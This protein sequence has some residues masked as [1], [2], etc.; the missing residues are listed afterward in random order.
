MFDAGALI[1]TIK[2]AGAQVFQ[3]DLRQ[4]DQAIEKTGRTAAAAKAPVEQLGTATDTTGKKSRAAKKPLDDQARSTERVGEEAA[5]AKPKQES[6]AAASERQAQSARQLSVALLAAGVAVT[7][8]VG[9]TV[10]KFASFDQA[11][12]NTAAATM[13]T[14][15]QQ[16][17]LGAAALEAGADSA[18]SA[19]EAAAAEEELAKAGLSV[20]EIIGGGLNASLGLAAAGQLEVAR[21][22]E[23]MATTLKQFK[24]PAEDAA[25]VSD[26]LAAGAGKAQGS[27]ED[28]ANAL[29]YVGPV[30]NG[31]G[32][33]VEETTGILALFAEQGILGEQA[34]TSLRGVLSSL[35]SPS[36]IAAATMKDYNVQ[37]FDGTGKM[38]SGAAVAQELHKAFDGLS[39]AERSAAMGRIFGNEQIT[40]A[41]ILMRG[42]ADAVNEWTEAVDDSGFAAE[43]AAKR[44]DN[45]AGDV[46]KLGGAFD[47]ALI[48]TGSG[49]NDV[50][51][52]MVQAVTGLVDGY[53]ELPDPVQQTTLVLGAAL[54]AMLLF[55]GGAL[56]AIS[57][58]ADLKKTLDG[59]NLTM[60]K[61]TLIAGGVGLALTAVVAVIGL[62]AT[63][64]AEAEQKA[65]SYSQALSQTGD[66][67]RK[68]VRETVSA[69]LAMKESFLWLESDSAY[70]AATKL[71]LSLDV[72]TDA[73]EGSAPALRKLN[74]Q[75]A[76]G[77]NGSARQKKRLEETGLSL[78]DY[79]LA[80]TTV[81]QAIDR[82]N[83][84]QERGAE[85]LGQKNEVTDDA[86]D[87][88]RNAAG[89][90][91]ASADEVSNYKDE[92]DGLIDQIM[93]L[94]GLNQDAASAQIDYGNT[95]AEVDEVIRKATEGLDENGDGVADYALTLD[96]ATQAGRDNKEMLIGL[97]QEAE[98]AARK[99]YEL[100]GNTEN[101]KATLEDSRQAL[102][103]RILAFTGNADAAGALADEIFRIP[104]K[105]EWDMIADTSVA[106][107]QA[108]AMA[109]Q[110]RD[111]PHSK[112]VYLYI[113]EQRIASGAPR[114]EVGAA[115]GANGFVLESYANGGT[116]EHHVA[117]IA[118]AGTWRVW[119]EDETGGEA[120]IPLAES[121]RPR[122]TAIL[123]DVAQRF[124]Y[125]LT[126]ADAQRY[127]DGAVSTSTDAS[128]GQPSGR[129]D[130]NLHVYYP[131]GIDPVRAIQEAAEARRAEGD[132]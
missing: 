55:S 102:Y 130:L 23:I 114:G 76:L 44:Q 63:A 105:T 77:E 106:M 46:E 65:E 131:S 31:L 73:A 84:A 47:T 56:G 119:A 101:Y 6:Q 33:S 43:Q 54:G 91:Q 112:T 9:L 94:N 60:G 40:A 3:Q 104:S 36:K 99:Q 82:E 125:S 10:A 70:D 62:V 19:N 32:I 24:L 28:L 117:Q 72:V 121:K 17:E 16:K 13:A 1:F 98:S 92:L 88:E 61:T 42:G 7:A 26:L 83:A 74:E 80:V 66:S 118:R 96:Q 113:E 100:D 38:K 97:A 8:L 127:A 95:L 4:S 37:V 107:Q 45:L 29:K 2:A 93:A 14:T 15:E 120:Y 39:D 128:F 64:Q 115:Y 59:A 78:S 27:V 90:Y 85:L 11:M 86:A 108:Q 81:M 71:G 22:A 51:R 20:S 50:L 123:A 52:N 132:L 21:S 103:D 58:F 48:K 87:S 41:T 5:K 129:G 110:I 68:A 69:N 122:S 12:S 111:I 67:A 124:G 57:R 116:R 34:G 53:G 126:P 35:T 25:H 30:A 18:Y 109:Q 89:A 49:A 75:V 79:G